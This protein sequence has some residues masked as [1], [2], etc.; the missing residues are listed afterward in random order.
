M[1]LSQPTLVPTFSLYPDQ[2]DCV[3]IRFILALVSTLTPVLISSPP[4]LA[5]LSYK[6]IDI[7]PQQSCGSTSMFQREKKWGLSVAG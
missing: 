2:P 4:T 6:Q 3:I 7:E 1:I 5:L